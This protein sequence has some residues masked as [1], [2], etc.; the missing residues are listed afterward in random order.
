VLLTA[1]PVR[2]PP[3]GA[4]AGILDQM[5]QSADCAFDPLYR[6]ALTPQHAVFRLKRHAAL[7]MAVL[8]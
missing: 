2:V 8:P 3:Q 7:T 5:L 6:D 1:Q 4:R